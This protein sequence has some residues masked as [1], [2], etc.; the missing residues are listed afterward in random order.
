MGKNKREWK[1][2]GDRVLLKLENAYKIYDKGRVCAL[3][4]VNLTVS[5]GEYLAVVGE[6]GSGKTTLMNLLGCLDVPTKG[7]C[8]IDGQDTSRMTSD[9]LARLRNEKIG[10]IFQNFQL[11]QRMT[12][13]ENV[14]LPLMFRGVDRQQ[15][16][17]IARL[18]LERVGLGHRLENYPS[19]MSGGQQQRTAIARAVAGRPPVILADE[20]TGNLDPA[21][22]QAVLKLMDGLAREGR[23]I[24]LITHDQKVA[25]R[26]HRRIRITGGK[27]EED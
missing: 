17:E 18:A 21:S 10:F 9:G 27:I 23:T 2:G 19:E 25:D 26:A 8:R 22:A 1:K 7:I 11:I 3:N 24:V 16:E 20:P 15:R 14:A 4:G 5:R 6:S 13:L 12:A